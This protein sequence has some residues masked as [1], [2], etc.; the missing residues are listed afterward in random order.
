MCYNQVSSQCLATVSQCPLYTA[1]M[2]TREALAYNPDRHAHVVLL[3]Q[4]EEHDTII[5][6]LISMSVISSYIN[7]DPTQKVGRRMSSMDEAA[8]CEASL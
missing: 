4:R 3:R 1:Q 5:M 6:R 7:V 8:N 2:A